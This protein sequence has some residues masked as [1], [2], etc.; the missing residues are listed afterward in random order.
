MIEEVAA[1]L[2]SI[3][4]GTW[5]LIVVVALVLLFLGRR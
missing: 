1:Y 2:A 5:R 3:D 4:S